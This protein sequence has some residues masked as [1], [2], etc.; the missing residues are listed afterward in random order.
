MQDFKKL[1]VWHLAH[2]LSLNVE[3][4]CDQ[5]RFSRRPNLRTQTVRAADSIATNISEGAGKENREFARYLEIALSSTNELENHLIR[6]RDSGILAE[7]R[8]TLLI[9]AADHVRR[10]V[11]RLIQRVR[12]KGPSNRLT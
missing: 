10:K 12:R 5:R 6:A 4:S 1:V 7:R 8:A 2:R 11:I 9:E 3:A